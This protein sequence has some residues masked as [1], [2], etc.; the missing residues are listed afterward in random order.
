M[1]TQRSNGRE[2]AGP[3]AAATRGRS[4]CRPVQRLV[5]AFLL[6]VLLPTLL[7][8]AAAIVLDSPGS[9][10]YRQR[11]LGLHG[12]E[13]TLY[14]L[15]SMCRGSVHDGRR[16]C[17]A[18]DRITRVGRFIRGSSLD[19]VPQLWNVVRGEMAL[20]GP[21]PLLAA[22]TGQSTAYRRRL[23]VL[24]GMTGLW[25]VSGRCSLDV[26][27][28][29]ALDVDYVDRCSTRLDLSILLRTPTAVLSR[30]GAY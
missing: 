23:E 3:V 13:F 5:A 29:L 6:V 10:V 16:K 12:R 30:R 21:R 2:S 28:A 20:V 27:V 17:P 22:D 18:D 9:P 8:L 15:R 14:K 1:P 26:E 25:Q 7:L 19:E 4:A 24:P 11:R